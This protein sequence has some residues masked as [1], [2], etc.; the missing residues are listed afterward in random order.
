MGPLMCGVFSIMR[1]SLLVQ[2]AYIQYLVRELRSC[3]PCGTTKKKI[4]NKTKKIL[5]Y[6]TILRMVE[7]WI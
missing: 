4:N 6:Y 2:W 5:Q 1:N 7:P 3:K